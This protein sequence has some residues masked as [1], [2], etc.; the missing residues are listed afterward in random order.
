MDFVKR[1]FSMGA[2]GP[3]GARARTGVT[4]KQHMERLTEYA[5]QRGSGK[6]FTLKV[7]MADLG[8][9]EPMYSTFA[10]A[11]W[12]LTKKR[13]LK[14]HSGGKHTAYTL[15]GSHRKPKGK[16]AHGRISNRYPRRELGTADAATT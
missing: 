7:A 15:R 14:K 3:G 8:L 13:V 12:M 11:T 6:P 5:V 16:N 1:V 9:T 10:K 4:L 2:A